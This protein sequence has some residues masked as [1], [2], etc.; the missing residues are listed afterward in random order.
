MSDGQ[1]VLDA[2]VGYGA[3]GSTTVAKK[4]LSKKKPDLLDY[5]LT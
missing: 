5:L 2:S 3:K 1:V 4:S